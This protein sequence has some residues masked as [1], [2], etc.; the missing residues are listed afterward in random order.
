MPPASLSPL[1]VMIPGPTTASRRIRRLWN[2]R[3]RCPTLMDG[4]PSGSVVEARQALFPGGRDD[5]VEGVVGRDNS[6]NAHGVVDYGYGRQ[7]VLRDDPGDLLLRSL[8]PDA[9]QARGHEG[10]DGRGRL[11]Q[12][13]LVQREHAR[14]P[15][16]L[17]DGVDIGDGLDLAADLA[18]Q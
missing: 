14:Q 3:S 2:G 8:E 17:V 4:R 12:H 15:P 18:Q 10:A 13:Q 6:V 1:A 5:L 16:L 9:D 7:V 11:S